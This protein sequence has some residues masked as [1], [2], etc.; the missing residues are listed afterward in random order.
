M[1]KKFLAI[2]NYGDMIGG[3]EYSFLSFLK[4]LP[5]QWEPLAVVPNTGQLRLLLEEAGIQ[6]SIIPFPPIRPWTIPRMIGC[7]SLVANLCKKTNP[8]LI[9]ANGSRAALYSCLAKP[10]HNKPVIFHCRIAE[11]DW[12][13]DLI[14]TRMINLIICN[15]IATTK[16]FN[17]IHNN[18]IRIV[19]NG[20]ELGRLRE[21]VKKSAPVGLD[22][23]II[24][25]VAR[26]SR[27]KRHDVALDTFEKIADSLP[28][29]H[30]ILIGDKDRLDVEWWEYLQTKTR[31]S[32]FSKR[33]HWPGYQRDI[34]PWY[35]SASILFAPG[36]NE[37]FGRVIIE[38][39]ACGLPV[40]ATRGGGIPEIVRHGEDG[41]LVQPGDIDEMANAIE[42]ILI[43]DELR[44][45]LAQ[46]AINRAEGFDLETHTEKMIKIFEQT[47]KT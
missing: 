31:M 35:R 37:A 15:S 24:L 33:I 43:N 42:N 39:M 18:K 3:G 21:P 17:K 44:K 14:L 4:S 46:S 6:T 12:K 7:I 2:S 22:W 13:M 1:N 40:I 34:R 32:P 11:K 36:E 9:Y 25:V 45:G 28:N 47:I 16:R 38:A 23:K 20:F 10:F 29:A 30:L 5:T 19:Y 26:I 8:E 27:Q 41:I